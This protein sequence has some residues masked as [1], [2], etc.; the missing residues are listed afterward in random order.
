MSA[1]RSARSVSRAVGVDRVRALQR[2]LYRYA[3]QDRDRRFHALFD[4]VARSDVMWRAWREVRANRGAPGVD[5]V[6]IEQVERSGAGVFLKAACWAASGRDVPAQAAAAGAYPQAGAAGT[7]LSARDS[8]GRRPGGHGGS[9]D[10]ARADLRGRL[11]AIQLRVSPEA[12]CASCP[13]DHQDDGQPGPAVGA[14]CLERL[15]WDPRLSRCAGRVPPALPT[16]PSPSPLS[17]HPCGD[18][19]ARAWRLPRSARELTNHGVELN[20]RR[21]CRA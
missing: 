8:H 12:F 5:G 14:R 13:G 11:P 9:E 15:V 7:D 4:K 20:R 18:R 19:L 1:G 21:H 3:K 10:R 17:G 2:V 6:T 16:S